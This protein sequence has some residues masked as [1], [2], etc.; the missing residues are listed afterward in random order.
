MTRMG[1]S[2]INFFEYEGGDD[3]IHKE[4]VDILERHYGNMPFV[5]S[6][7]D[8]PTLEGMHSAYCKEANGLSLF[9]CIIKT[10]AGCEGVLIYWKEQ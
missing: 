9:T 4:V 8:I 2:K 1:Y 5:L 3:W 7:K 10:I 6:I